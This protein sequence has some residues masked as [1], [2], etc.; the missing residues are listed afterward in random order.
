MSNSWI[1][2]ETFG[3]EEPSVIG[4]GSSPKSFVSPRHVLRSSAS[5][6]EALAAVTE[7]LVTGAMVDRLSRDRYRRVLAE[8]LQTFA[9]RTHGAWVWLGR[10]D[11]TPP[12]RDATGAWQFNLTNSTA[13]GSNDLLDLYRVPQNE[14]ETQRA[15]AGAFTRLVTNRDESEA[16]AKIVQS[17]PGT[18]HQAVWTVRRDDG[19][20]RAAHF[21]CRMIA[22]DQAAG[23][24]I[25]LRGITH[26]IG[27]AGEITI[28]PPPTILEHRVLEAST[29]EGEYRALVNLRTLNLLRWYNSEPVPNICW[30]NLPDE[31]VPAI[32]PD[33]VP[34]AKQMSNA[35]ARERTNAVLRFR[36]LDGHWK[37]M[38]VNAV[39]VSLDQH[40][41]A[42]L[43]TLTELCEE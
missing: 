38:K 26:D 7:T 39:L 34:I 5:R 11:E 32:H 20:L 40:T 28:A 14:R 21:S 33:D 35:L 24:E 6:N 15:L 1:L 4:V 23:T 18:T 10:R 8:P 27:P 3:D 9:G 31:P 37:P 22:E 29:K 16:M 17:A 25:I 2:I 12:P 42:A 43:V 41:T 36:T 19:E 30:E 13:S